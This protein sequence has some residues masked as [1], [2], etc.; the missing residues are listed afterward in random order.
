MFCLGRHAEELEIQALLCRI[1]YLG[2][3]VGVAW[4]SSGHRKIARQVTDSHAV[5]G[6][7]ILAMDGVIAENGEMDRSRTLFYI[8]DEF[9]PGK[10]PVT[11]VF[12]SGPASIP[13]DPS[14]RRIEPFYLKLIELDLSL[15]SHAGD[16]RSF[17]QAA[18]ELADPMRLRLPLELGVRVIAAHIGSTGKNQGRTIWSER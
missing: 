8:P 13:I 15:L 1:Q 3:G 16:E 5:A 7:V 6:A 10:Q 2:E 14:D 9:V 11:L 12:I 17:T 18:D 4:R